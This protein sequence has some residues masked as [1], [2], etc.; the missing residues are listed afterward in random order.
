MRLN[1][2]NLLGKTLKVFFK[3]NCMEFQALL[4]LSLGLWLDA[5][6]VERQRRIG[7]FGKFSHSSYTGTVTG[8][9]HND[10]VWCDT[11][12]AGSAQTSGCVV[13]RDMHL[14]IEQFDIEHLA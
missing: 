6:A 8:K 13:N 3:L 4:S 2:K 5:T 9:L 10:G 14:S 1:L 7:K 12:K 11:S